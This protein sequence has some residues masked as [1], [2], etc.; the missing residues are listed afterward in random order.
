M[1]VP[2]LTQCCVVSPFMLSPAP[3][4]AR[5]PGVSLYTSAGDQLT[6]VFH[7][8]EGVERSPWCRK[9]RDGAGG[10]ERFSWERFSPSWSFSFSSSSSSSSS[11]YD[12]SSWAIVSLAG[13]GLAKV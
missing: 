11:S 9:R 1:A 8:R 13:G 2:L 7:D 12:E 4:D 5:P 3:R 10:W 6:T